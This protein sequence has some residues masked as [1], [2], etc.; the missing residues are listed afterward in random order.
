MRILTRQELHTRAVL[1]T[2]IVVFGSIALWPLS[3]AGEAFGEN[4]DPRALRN[5]LAIDGA[6]LFVILLVVV[7]LLRPKSWFYVSPKRRTVELF[8][9]RKLVQT[10]PF[11]RIGP[12]S[13]KRITEHFQGRHGPRARSRYVLKS[14]AF[15]EYLLFVKSAG[16]LKRRAEQLSAM[17]GAHLRIEIE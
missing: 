3:M 17:L 11:D 12:L 13:G 4:A 7:R 14:P 5:L 1:W 2:L 16:E 8:Q 15:E 10:E 6:S 9:K